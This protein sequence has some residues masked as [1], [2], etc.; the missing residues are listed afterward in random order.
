LVEKN[1]THTTVSCTFDKNAVW[2]KVCCRKPVVLDMNA[3]IN[4]GDEKSYLATRVKGALRKL[5]S[6]SLIFCPL[7]SGLI[8]ELYKQAEDSR[9]RVGTLM[10]ELSLNVSYASREEIFAWEV[11]RA[12]R[13]LADAGPIDLSTYEIY[14]PV[15]AYIASRFHL[16]FPEGFPSEHVEDFTRKCKERLESL[17]FTEILM[18]RAATK[19]DNIFE[20]IKELPAPKYSE[21]ARRTRDMAKG[22]KQKIQRIEA[23]GTFKQ[24]ILPAIRKLPWLVQAKFLDYCKT[25]PKDKYGGCFSELIN[26]LPAIRNHMELMAAVTQQPSRKDKINDFFDNEIMPVPLAY[27]SVFVAQD[28]GIMD[29]LQNRTKVLDR[30]SC[31]YCYDLG[32]LEAWLNTKAV[33]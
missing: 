27:A 5:V 24:H 20:Y 6:D 21:E 9:L 17:T 16:D 19:A 31:R 13:R 15:S 11:E 18:M 12:V 7:S 14:V 30:S 29:V 8:W 3:W 4:M 2:R 28:K 25:G 1:V 22:D 10:E 33:V 23:E 32:E 26:Y